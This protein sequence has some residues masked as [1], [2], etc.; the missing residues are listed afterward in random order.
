MKKA[1][2]IIGI[3]LV[4]GIVV[5]AG[6]WYYLKSQVPK[7][8]LTFEDCVKAGNLVVD[9]N[10]RECHMKDGKFYVEEDNHVALK[11]VIVVKEPKSYDSVTTPFKVEGEAI[12][13]WY[14][15]QR[16]IIKLLDS[17]NNVLVQKVA[18]AKGDIKK[19]KMVEFEAAV[20][21]P[22]TDDTRGKLLI[23]KTSGVDMPGKNG[24][25]VIPV[26]FSKN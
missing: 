9:T 6:Y 19:N 25:L 26:K 18:F 8:I 7:V 24:P 15:E 10:P 17:H 21:F 3:I 16:L 22:A 23:E 4:I 13:S 11:D 20:S 14:G 5:V 12:A 1:F 2:I